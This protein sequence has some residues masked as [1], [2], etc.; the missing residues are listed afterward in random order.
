VR[1]DN[2]NTTLIVSGRV[3]VIYRKKIVHKW[4]KIDKKDDLEIGGNG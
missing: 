1:L 4:M 2:R 3:R